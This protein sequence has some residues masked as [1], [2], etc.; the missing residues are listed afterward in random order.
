MIEYFEKIRF[1]GQILEEGMKVQDLK[2]PTGQPIRIQT[3]RWKDSGVTRSYSGSIGLLAAFTQ[4]RAY[5]AVLEAMD[6]TWSSSRLI[7]LNAAASL[8]F[9]VPNQMPHQNALIPCRFMA[10]YTSPEIGEDEFKVAAQ[11]STG[12][13][14]ATE[15]TLTISATTGLITNVKELR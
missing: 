3:I 7:I 15:R 10:V 13:P 8:R 5:V 12:Y 6:S 2:N 11:P 9:E 4:D 14:F 1:D